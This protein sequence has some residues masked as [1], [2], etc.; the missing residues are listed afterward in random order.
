VARLGKLLEDRKIKLEL[1]EGARAWLG[2]M[3]YDPVYGARPLKRAVQK[4]L[5]DPLAD[6]ILSGEIADGAMVRVEEGE[7]QLVLTTE[8]LQAAAA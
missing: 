7:G 6:K 1:T 4:H 5:Q 2:R 3:G 8:Q